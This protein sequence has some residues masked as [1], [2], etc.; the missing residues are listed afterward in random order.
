MELYNRFSTYLKNR[1]GEKTQKIPINIPVTCPNRDGRVGRLG[2]IFCG[3]DGAGFE[4]LSNSIP[5]NEQMDS[6]I[7]YIGNAY[8]SKKFIVYFQS[9]T[10]TYIEFSKFKKYIEAAIRPQV[11]AIYISTRPDVINDR[12]LEFLYEIKEEHKVDVVIELGLQS[13]NVRTLK[14]LERGHT[15]AHFLDAVLRI[16]R[17]KLD[18]CAHMILDIPNDDM[19]DVV[20]GARILS[21]LGVDQV[22]CHSMYI[23]EGTKLAKYYRSGYVVP[24]ER[25]E[26]IERVINFLENLS[27][28][29]VVQRLIGRA[30]KERTIFCN[31]DSSWWKIRDEIE[32]EMRHRGTYQGKKFD[33]VNGIKT[34]GEKIY[35]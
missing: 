24:I 7:N 14:F 23:L 22:K 5:V 20:E 18:V 27:S 25:G 10:N 32:D 11:V 3:E 2:C 17:N 1:Y 30:P 31:W 26:Y 35:N 6:N 29:I 34:L 4:C 21:V 9:F 28:N 15:L 13:V 12:Y 8:N 16:K 19:D 33:Y